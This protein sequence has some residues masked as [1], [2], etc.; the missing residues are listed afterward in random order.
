M[1][2]SNLFIFDTDSEYQLDCSSIFW[3]N[4]QIFLLPDAVETWS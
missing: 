4:K 1:E 2:L 3:A